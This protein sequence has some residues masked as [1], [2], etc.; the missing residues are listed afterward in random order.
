MC[1]AKRK[2]IAG[3]CLG[4][5]VLILSEARPGSTQT[6][7]EHLQQIAPLANRP[8]RLDPELRNR[9][10]TDYGAARTG[11]KR[12]VFRRYLSALGADGILDALEGR[13]AF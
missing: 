8:G 4:V 9:F 3:I 10:L 13:N 2:L 1:C 6:E 5:I 12:A 7:L 11:E